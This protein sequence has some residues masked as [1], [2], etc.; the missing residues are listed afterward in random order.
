MSDVFRQFT[1]WP[2][3]GAGALYVIRSEVRF[4]RK[5]RRMLPGSADRGSTLAVS[6]SSAIP[7]RGFVL[8]MK[9]RGSPARTLL[10]S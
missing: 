2:G 10:P 7:V 5:A 1:A 9:T 4:G 3:Y 6:L 8:A